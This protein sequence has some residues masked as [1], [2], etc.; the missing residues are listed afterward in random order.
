MSYGAPHASGHK[1]GAIGPHIGIQ[2]RLGRAALNME[3][4]SMTYDGTIR[5]LIANY[6]ADPVSG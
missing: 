5:S 2:G 1:C 6:L 3:K 4:C